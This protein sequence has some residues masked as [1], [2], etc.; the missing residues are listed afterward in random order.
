M[1]GLDVA[2][3]DAT[4]SVPTAE[5]EP[6][7]EFNKAIKFTDFG[8]SPKFK[9]CTVEWTTTVVKRATYLVAADDNDFDGLEI[10]GGPGAGWEVRYHKTPAVCVGGNDEDSLDDASVKVE[11]IDQHDVD[12]S[13]EEQAIAWKDFLEE[14]RVTRSEHEAALARKR[15]RAAERAAAESA[16]GPVEA[17]RAHVE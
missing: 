15:E 12:M 14:E 13:A 11:Y 8:D 6:A 1:V 3:A 16:E 10:G 7:T 5:V 2:P 9:M 17:K 4:E